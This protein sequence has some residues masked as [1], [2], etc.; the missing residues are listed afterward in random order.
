LAPARMIPW[1]STRL[2]IMKPGTS[3]RYKSGRP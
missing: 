3:A 1:R 2:P